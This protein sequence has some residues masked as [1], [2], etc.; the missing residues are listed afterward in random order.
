MGRKKT[1]KNYPYKVELVAF[2]ITN[3]CSHRCPYCY[4]SNDNIKPKHPSKTKL[5][6]IIDALGASKIKY[7]SLLG[8]DPASYPF[9]IDISKY[10]SEKYK[11]EV[12][13]LSNTLRFQNNNNEEA[14]KYISAFETTIHHVDPTLHDKFCNRKNA[15]KDVVQQLYIFSKLGRKTGIAINIIPEIHDK[16]YAMVDRIVNEYN[17]PLDYIIVQR[18]IPFGRAAGKSDFTLMRKQAEKSLNEIIRIDKELGISITI[19]DPFPLC[20]LTES[21]KKYMNPCL[22]GFTKASVNYEGDLSR[23]GADPRYRLGNII[24]TP[25]LEIWNNSDVL[26]SFRSKSYLPGRCQICKDIEKCGGGCPLSCEIEK[27]H[28][29]DYLFMEYEKINEEIHGDIT[30]SEAKEDELSS[31]LQI[32]WSDF[33]GYGHIFSVESIRK[34]YHHNSN[35]FWVVRDSRNWVL[36]YAALAPITKKL[37]QRICRGEFSSLVQFPKKEVL[38]DNASIY[39]HIEVLASVPSRTATRAGRY[40]IKSIGDVLLKNAKYV[41][42]S[43]VSDIGLR[44]CKYFNFKFVANEIAKDHTYPIHSLIVNKQKIDRKLKRF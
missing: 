17:V 26:E 27:D 15:Y 1:I 8:G 24:K 3:V 33:P 13:I 35:M 21:Q 25:L 22:W 16:I 20:V 41:T 23:C 42:A 34:W 7:L 30:F 5:F 19:E 28:G 18:I 9:V 32:E 40:L 12:S 6:T 4:A 14:A 11:M 29:I 31:I 10:A 39:Y 36:G 43:P 38:K 37:F 44:L 2:H